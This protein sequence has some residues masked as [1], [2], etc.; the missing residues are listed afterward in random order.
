MSSAAPREVIRYLDQ[1][2]ESYDP[3]F[4]LG[5]PERLA[6]VVSL[7]EVDPAARAEEPEATWRARFTAL[8]R[9][10][11]APR[12]RTLILHDCSEYTIDSLDI[13]FDE[14]DPI[15]P[16][17]R[18]AGRLA[19]LERLYVGVFPP[20]L[21]PESGFCQGVGPAL[22]GLP[23][24]EHLHLV[25][26]R[27]WDLLPEAGHPRLRS[28]QMH[29]VEADD[30]PLLA[31]EKAVFPALERLDLWAG[32]SLLGDAEPAGVV[33][34]LAR[35]PALRELALRGLDSSELLVELAARGGGPPL[36][37]LA[38][39]HAPTLDDDALAVLLAAPWLSR[40]ARLDLDGTAVS[41]A[42]AAE[43]SARGPAVGLRPG[44]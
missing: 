11:Q 2:V 24:L 28:L 22:S 37:T 13:P 12:L 33:E 14:C 5:L 39:T 38:L 21:P 40:L 3:A 43:L 41:A 29:V 44:A 36:Q 27:G 35:M 23:A 19:R 15:R 10:P 31:L 26:E 25:G 6:Y 34:A 20:A 32:S 7:A 1:I 42:L 8:L 16:L 18:H 4:G 30:D 17:R 9:D